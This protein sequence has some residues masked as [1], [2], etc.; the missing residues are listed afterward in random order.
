MADAAKQ[1][2]FQFV[3]AGAVIPGYDKYCKRYGPIAA[4]EYV[5]MTKGRRFVDPLLASY[6]R[7]GFQVPDKS[8]VKANYYPDPDSHNYAALVVKSV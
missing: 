8:H 3:V 6:Q 1:L 5:F 2:K 4:E 7:I